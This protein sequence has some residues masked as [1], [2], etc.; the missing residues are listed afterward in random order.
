M[1]GCGND[2][3]FEGVIDPNTPASAEEA[4]ELTDEAYKEV[5]DSYEQVVDELIEEFNEEALDPDIFFAEYGITSVYEEKMMQMEM[6]GLQA[7]DALDDILEKDL[8]NKADWEV[9]T[10]KISELYNQKML[11]LEEAH[12]VML[13]Y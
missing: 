2:K 10:N 8:G 3:P 13:A 4:D 9:W 1:L 12:E 6:D 11:E 7:Q 5:Y